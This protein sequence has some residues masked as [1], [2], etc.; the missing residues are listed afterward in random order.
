MSWPPKMLRRV[1]IYAPYLYLYVYILRSMLLNMFR[2]ISEIR[3]SV[4]KCRE[5][6]KVQSSIVVTRTQ[7]STC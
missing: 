6:K 2:S 5:H 3:S 7:I 1:I 4:G